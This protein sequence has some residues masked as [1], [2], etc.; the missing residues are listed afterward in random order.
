MITRTRLSAGGAHGRVS[1]A[2]VE[3]GAGASAPGDVSCHGE[4]LGRW[5]GGR[6]EAS[7]GRRDGD[8]L[9][10]MACVVRASGSWEVGGDAGRG[11]KECGG[12]GRRKGFPPVLM[13]IYT[14]YLGL[15]F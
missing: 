5:V 14:R 12:Q 8:V 7:I 9:A 2:S 4:A 3:G 13:H 11:K 1:G 6:V 10:H 15:E